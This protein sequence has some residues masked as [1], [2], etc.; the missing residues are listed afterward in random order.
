MRAATLF[1]GK[2]N[3]IAY[4]LLDHDADTDRIDRRFDTAFFPFAPAYRDGIQ[5]ELLAPPT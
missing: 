3:E 4:R 5:N 2:L 1:M